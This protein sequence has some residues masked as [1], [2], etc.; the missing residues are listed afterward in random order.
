MER[1]SPIPIVALDYETLDAALQLV[2]RLGP[3]CDFYKVGSALFTEVGPAA[4]QALRERNKRVFLD[5]KFNDIPQTVAL[6]SGSAARLGASLITVHASG[7]PAMLSAAVKGAG[8]ACKVLAVT[9]LT[10]LESSGVAEVWGRPV[11]SVE[12]EVVRLARL[13]NQ[14]G[15][16]GVV[17]SGAELQAVRTALGERLATLVPGIRFVDGERH[18]QRRVVSPSEA[19]AWGATYIVAGRMITDAPE[20][21][22]A[23]QRLVRELGSERAP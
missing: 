7:G 14:C 9:I 3:L 19:A 23:M 2:D 13:A 10:S 6:A 8:D 11:V 12:S 22:A 1:V 21:S 16:H 5:L 4:V 15:V 17:S 20:P 18:D